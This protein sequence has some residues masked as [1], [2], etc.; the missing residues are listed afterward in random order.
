MHINFCYLVLLALKLLEHNME[1]ARE[2]NSLLRR[3]ADRQ[4]SHQE[5]MNPSSL[6]KGLCSIT[7]KNASYSGK[8]FIKTQYL[9]FSTIT[10]G[11]RSS[12]NYCLESHWLG[13]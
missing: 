12:K 7:S 5:N 8:K 13:G 10:D 9:S 11:F 3:E 1:T 2:N 4:G 6:K